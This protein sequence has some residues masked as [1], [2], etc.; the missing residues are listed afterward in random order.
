[1]TKVEL[2]ERRKGVLYTVSF[3]SS[4]FLHRRNICSFEKEYSSFEVNNFGFR[5][6]MCWL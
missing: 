6:V 4:Q 1:M 5:A 2:E 3:R